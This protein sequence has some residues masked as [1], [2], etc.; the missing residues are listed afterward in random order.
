MILQIS[1]QWSRKK[2]NV[3]R[4]Y[5][6]I[7][8]VPYRYILNF[9]SISPKQCACLP[10]VSNAPEVVSRPPWLKAEVLSAHAYNLRTASQWLL[11]FQSC[12]VGTL[13][14]TG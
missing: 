6:R 13:Y 12:F 9:L 10:A 3:Y 7:A 5:L 2:E 8:A 1:N 14:G 11:A 4:C